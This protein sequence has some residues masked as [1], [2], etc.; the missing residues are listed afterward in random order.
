MLQS[1]GSQRV[2]HDLATKEQEQWRMGGGRPLSLDS[3]RRATLLL[4]PRDCPGKN[5]GVS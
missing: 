3:R 2:G 1:M 4:H 5:T